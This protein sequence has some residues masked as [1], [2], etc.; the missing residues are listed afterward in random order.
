MKCEI[1]IFFK[2][3][4]LHSRHI[5]TIKTVSQITGGKEPA[6]HMGCEAAANLYELCVHYEP[7]P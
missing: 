3:C 6:Y 2:M 1:C 5:E 7:K 4:G